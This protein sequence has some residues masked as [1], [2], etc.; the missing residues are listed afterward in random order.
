LNTDD[1][2][3]NWVKWLRDESGIYPVVPVNWDLIDQVPYKNGDDSTQEKLERV[4]RSIPP[5]IPM[6][7]R[8]ELWVS[9]FEPMPR[10]AIRVHYAYMPEHRRFDLKLTADQWND[11]RA[12][13]VAKILRSEGVGFAMAVDTYLD[14]VADARMQLDYW[15]RKWAGGV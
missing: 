8:V 13:H 6:A 9:Q 15:F 11:W 10:A 3:D 7:E 14:A 2:L 4:E 12:R 5:D 1:L